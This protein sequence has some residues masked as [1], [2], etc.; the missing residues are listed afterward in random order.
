MGLGLQGGRG[1]AAPWGRW[2]FLPIQMT[3]C[4]VST[5]NLLGH[6]SLGPSWDLVGWSPLVMSLPIPPTP[7][8]HLRLGTYLCSPEPDPVPLPV[9]QPYSVTTTTPR[10]SVSGTTS[11]VETA[12]LRPAE[13][14]TASTPT[15]QCPTWRVSW[16]CDC[17][18]GRPWGDPRRH[19]ERGLRP[20]VGQVHL[21]AESAHCLHGRCRRGR[22]ANAVLKPGWDC[23]GRDREAHILEGERFTLSF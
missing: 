4:M 1:S 3:A 17:Q 14:S 13:P 19:L 21:G 2:Y 23:R 16:G 6:P 9:P 15:S 18:I 10:M 12:A 7:Q 8:S 11:P 22:L 5:P 20:T